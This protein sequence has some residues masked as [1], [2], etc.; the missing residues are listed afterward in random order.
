MNRLFSIL[1]LAVA[2]TQGA[3]AQEV[4]QDSVAYQIDANPI[5]GIVVTARARDRSKRYFRRYVRKVEDHGWYVGFTG[6][7]RIE[8]GGLQGWRSQGTYTRN[9]IPGDDANRHRIDLF[10]LSAA[11]AADSTHLWDI[12]RY[13]LLAVSIAERADGLGRESGATLSYR[14]KDDDGMNVFL[15]SER[16]GDTRRSF[17]TRLLVHDASR[18]VARS[19]SVSRSSG[20]IWNVTADYALFDGFIYPT[21]VAADFE[22]RDPLSGQTVTVNVSLTGIVP[23]RFEREEATGN[24]WEGSGNTTK[25]VLKQRKAILKY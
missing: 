1:L 12:Q 6:E 10:S 4:A 21:R 5:E 19:E 18:I 3:A 24:Y 13:I 2:A 16:E 15:V 8:N 23:R 20:G 17:R 22:H 11:S 7:Y 25:R 14:G 9:H